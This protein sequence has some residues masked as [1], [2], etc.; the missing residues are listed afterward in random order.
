MS[1]TIAVLVALTSLAL[2]AHAWSALGHKTVAEIAWRQLDPKT[3][4]SVVELLRRHPRFDRDF[5][6]KMD[7]KL[8]DG[9]K[10]AEDHWIF[11]QAAIWPDEIRKVKDF[12]HPEW[13]YISVPLYLDK[14]DEQALA[15]TFHPNL[16]TTYRPGTPTTHLN[17]VQA[18]D[19]AR[20]TINSNAGP[21][22]KA[23]A[24][25]WLL[26]LVGDLHQPLH[27]NELVSVNQFPKGDKGG[28]EIPLVKGKELHALWDGLLGKQHYLR[29]VSKAANELSDKS[30]FGDIWESAASETDPA[31]WADE[32]HALCVSDVYTDA[33]LDAVRQTKPGDKMA[34]IDLPTSY[35]QSAG[36]LARKRILT[37]GL[38][39]STLLNSLTPRK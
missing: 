5:A 8:L 22:A 23:V 15:R 16:A 11:L 30:K 25:C 28:N 9:S 14:S 2:K 31:K 7:D 37:A 4:Q 36:A 10:E 19:F 26:H 3:R 12:D 17:A 18:L 1:R 35:Y 29:D 39:L 21:D 24:L 20:Q 38:R 13:H 33:I 32:S 6:S 34:P 27:C